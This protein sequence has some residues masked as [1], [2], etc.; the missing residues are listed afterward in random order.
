MPS[1]GD[2]TLDFI[3]EAGPKAFT[4]MVPASVRLEIAK[5]TDGAYR[6]VLK[7]LAQQEWAAIKAEIECIS[8][9]NAA[10]DWKAMKFGYP[11]ARFPQGLIEKF[12]AMYGEECWPDEEFIED[13][14]RHHPG[15][16]CNVKR[17]SRGL[18]WRKS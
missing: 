5:Q 9:E 16:R 12:K 11:Y 14:L 15:L 1:T 17:N 7:E 6:E 13:I 2:T 18:E 10:T 3:Q 4:P 8:I